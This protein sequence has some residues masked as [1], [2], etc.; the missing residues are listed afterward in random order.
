M[1]STLVVKPWVHVEFCCKS[2][3][4]VASIKIVAENV[5]M[6]DADWGTASLAA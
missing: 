4:L 2:R 6:N 1:A 3:K 5:P